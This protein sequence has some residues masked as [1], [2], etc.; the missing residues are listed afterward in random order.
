MWRGDRPIEGA[1]AALDLIRAAGIRVAFITNESKFSTAEIGN[2][3]NRFGIVADANEVITV[4]S[5]AARMLSR[6]PS[7]RRRALVIG[8][9][10]L[11]DE[12]VRHGI[13]VISHD[14]AADADVVVLAAHEGLMFDHLRAA[15]VA[16]RQGAKL[17]GLGRDAVF[18]S[19]T[20]VTPGTGA[21]L[22]AV[23]VAGGVRA[24]VVGKPEPPIFKMARAKLRGCSRIAVVGDNL[25]S[26]VWGAKRAGLLAILVLTGI[27]RLSDVKAAP[28]PP[29]LV[30]ESLAVLPSAIRFPN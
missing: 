7:K 18:P 29:D 8:P 3:L 26:D 30:V 9:A 16:V 12:L 23:E 17:Y 4:S 14:Q 28:E 15:T 20:G 10:A 2:R 27:A 24:F 1:A 5:V 19:S 13:S 21:I 11:S 22:A 6:P 25:V